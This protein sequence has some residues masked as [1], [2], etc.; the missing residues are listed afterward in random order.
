M[1]SPA[2]YQAGAQI[3]LKETKVKKSWSQP[4]LRTYGN[5]EAITLQGQVPGTNPCR[6]IGVG[7]P[8]T[9]PNGI[10]KYCGFIDAVNQI[11]QDMG[12]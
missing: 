3:V 11:N 2:D 10:T 12:S 9:L 5:V 1:N 8:V 4:I 6:R 7:T